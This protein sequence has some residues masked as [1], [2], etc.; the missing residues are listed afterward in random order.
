MR[1]HYVELWLE[2]TFPSESAPATQIVGA[3]EQLA[4]TRPSFSARARL[5]SPI[6]AARARPLEGVPQREPEPVASRRSPRLCKIKEQRLP[7]PIAPDYA[8]LSPAGPHLTEVA[9]PP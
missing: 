2:S 1:R 7:A 6:R 5:R 3:S 8:A 9:V 4:A